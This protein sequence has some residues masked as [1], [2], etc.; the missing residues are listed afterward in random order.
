MR[1]RP[2]LTALAA[3]AS[4]SATAG[5][6]ALESTE[7]PPDPFDVDE[8]TTEPTTA[9][10]YDG[11]PRGLESGFE[12]PG[13]DD[14]EVVVTRPWDI[15]SKVGI[16]VGVTEPPSEAGPA[17]L[18]ASI[19]LAESAEAPVEL[20][21]GATPP[22]SGYHGE[23]MD[24]PREMLLVPRR[25][26]VEMDDVVKRDLGCWRTRQQPFPEP[27]TGTVVLDP[28]ES[29]GRE[30]YLVT[31]WSSSVC[32]PSGTFEFE[33]DAGWSFHV[34]S[35]DLVQPDRSRFEEADV[36]DLPG[37][38]GT[39]WFHDPDPR[40][41]VEP[42]MQSL[43][44]RGG[45]TRLVFHNQRWRSVVAGRRSWALYKFV[46]DDW[47]PIAPLSSVGDLSHVL[48]GRTS[49]V[50]LSFY[51]NPNAPS[52]EDPT[53][54]GGLGEGTYAVAYPADLTI[55]G[56]VEVDDDEGTKPT[57]ALVSLVGQ[58][59]AFE[60][61]DAVDHVRD[62]AGVRHVY[63]TADESSVATLRL[64]EVPE[65]DGR[66]GSDLQTLVLEQ[67]LQRDALRDALVTFRE[68][69]DDVDAIVYH[70]DASDIEDV[71]AWIDPDGDGL[72]F[73]FEDTGYRGSYG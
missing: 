47:Y 19:G 4:T 23:A 37:F 42:Q 7:R 29:V 57:A 50:E 3:A 72:A 34:S 15:P 43:G 56:P 40:L 58:Q 55:P 22:L 51:T 54:V 44:L 60:A 13:D 8:T 66:D 68:A 9:L 11:P 31:P 69:G 18:F 32:L 26:G 61:S 14:H 41:F 71:T 45:S 70:T 67:V 46:D 53:S 63:T 52:P 27:T 16:T 39:R 12:V 28:G 64:R 5:C 62:E 36:P 65:S 10:D 21:A 38:A 33:A 1:R 73:W 59:P 6:S 25:A 24:G 17:T 48:P 20:P 2:L 30:Y 49:E 35:F